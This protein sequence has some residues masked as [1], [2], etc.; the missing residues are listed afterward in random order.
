MKKKLGLLLV[1]IVAV[2]AVGCAKET[3]K[4]NK[5]TP[6]VVEDKFELDIND[7]DKIFTIIKEKKTG[8][9]YMIVEDQ[10]EDDKFGITELEKDGE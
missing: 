6:F 7:S 10:Y 4:V 2:G 9:R 1:G 5:D 3:V 8:D